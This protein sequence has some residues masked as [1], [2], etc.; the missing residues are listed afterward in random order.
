MAAP[1]ELKLSHISIKACVLVQH[2][3]LMIYVL[4]L[5]A[6]NALSI[7]FWT[8]FKALQSSGLYP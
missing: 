3:R 6:F 7:L 5:P 4:S 1:E 2:A 8:Y